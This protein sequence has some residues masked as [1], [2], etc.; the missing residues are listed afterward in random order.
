VFGLSYFMRSGYT[1]DA[2]YSAYIMPLLVQGIAMAI[3]FVAMLTITLDGVPGPQVP[4]ASGL[5]N[6]LR[7]I[8]GSF[9]T[10]I[11]TTFWDDHAALHQSRLSEASSIYDN[12]AREALAQLHSAGLTDSQALAVLTRELGN[13][14]HLMSAVDFFWIAGWLCWGIAGLV[15]FARRPQTSGAPVVA[16]D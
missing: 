14:A 13:Q 8:T 12:N 7:I 2:S 15:W 4:A 5:S 3:F 9:A 1:A 16:A 10:S 11:T 6:F